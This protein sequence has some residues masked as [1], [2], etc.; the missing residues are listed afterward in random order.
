MTQKD[1]RMP[2]A[3]PFG[4]K[5]IWDATMEVFTHFSKVC[6]ENDLR[7]F[8]AFGTA[9]GAVRHQG[10][11]PWDDDFD[12]LMPREDYDKFLRIAENALPEYL[13]LV[14]WENTPEYPHIFAKVMDTREPVVAGI[15]AKVGFPLNQGVFIDIFPIDGFPVTFFARKMWWF[16]YLFY[17]CV[18]WGIQKRKSKTFVQ[19][20]ERILGFAACLMMPRI[21]SQRDFMPYLERLARKVPYKGSVWCGYMLDHSFFKPHIHSTSV[22]AES[23]LVDFY[24][25][26]IRLAQDIDSYLKVEYGDYLKLP[27]SDKQKPHHRNQ[28]V[29]PWKFGPTHGSEGQEV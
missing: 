18:E 17:R 29:A 28:F 6:E 2:N 4:L 27:P 11:I 15:E 26:S 16:T 8:G 12:V 9:L 13:R 20:V 23:K 7:Y 3:D 21:R 22:F 1:S 24:N 25:G 10:F 14:T 5:P 19:R